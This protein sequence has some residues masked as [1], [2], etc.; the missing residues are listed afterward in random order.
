MFECQHRKP[1]PCRQ[2][3]RHQQYDGPRPPK[4]DSPHSYRFRLAALDAPTLG[5][6]DSPDVGIREAAR[7]HI[8]AEAELVATYATKT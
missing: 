3:F 6:G 1:A 4:G 5:I 7:S 2:C 8:L